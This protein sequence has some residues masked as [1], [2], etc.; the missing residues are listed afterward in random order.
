MPSERLRH[1]APMLLVLA[2]RWLAFGWMLVVA[3]LSGQIQRPIEAG[4]VLFATG[5]WTAWLTLAAVRRMGWVLAADL[6]MAVVLIV[7]Y[8]HVYPPDAMLT[9][10][11]SF[12]G[13][14][15]TAAVA[16]CGVVHR[17][18][19]GA[20]AGALLGLVL[21]FAYAANEVALASL[22]FLQLL[23]MIA[24]GLSYVLL[25]GAVGVAAGQLDGLHRQLARSGEQAARLAERQ[26]L[27]ARIH[28]DV[29]QHFARLRARI[30]ELS[31]GPA[32]SAVAEGIARQE[33]VLRDL[34]LSGPTTSQPGSVSLRDRLAGL[35]ERHEGIPVRLVASGP[36]RLPGDVVDEI[37]AVVAELLTNVVKHARA[38]RVW[39]T[40]LHD[41]EHVVV[42]VR[43]DGVG[44]VPERETDGLGLRLSVHARVDR[45]AG[46]T[47]IRSGPGRG[48]EVE[49]RVPVALAVGG[50]ER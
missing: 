11:P 45:L 13:A 44:F 40:I 50:G 14:Y 28:D 34:A 38:R 31:D 10:H 15:P 4:V 26:R 23:T 5:C 24:W 42:S 2:L 1:P 7:V 8:G 6:G 20:A 29:L 16:A 33:T 12:M 9:D 47:R 41:G 36:V 32:L 35:A 49:L 22:S 3:V 27:V 19:G 46:R 25:G 30:G 18:P 43:D 21:P 17:L 48:T 39:L 37:G